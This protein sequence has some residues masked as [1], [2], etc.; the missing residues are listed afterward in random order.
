MIRLL[1]IYLVLAAGLSAAGAW[2][3]LMVPDG[4]FGWG[5]H[6]ACLRFSWILG[7]IVSANI[8]V[9]VEYRLIPERLRVVRQRLGAHLGRDFEHQIKGFE[10]FIFACG[11]GHLLRPIVLFVPSLLPVLVA[12]DW[13]TL[14]ASRSARLTVEG[15]IQ[16]IEALNDERAEAKAEALRLRGD[17]ARLTASIDGKVHQAFD[18]VAS[19]EALRTALEAMMQTS[20][21]PVVLYDLDHLTLIIASNGFWRLMGRVPQRGIDLLSIIHPDEHE[22][23]REACRERPL[24]GINPPAYHTRHLHADGSTVWLT[25]WA[26]YVPEKGEA[27]LAWFRVRRKEEH[28]DG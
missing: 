15:T 5:A 12:A 17:V 27:P 11:A 7:P 2:R 24:S 18:L 9:A 28:T 4:I 6:A 22:A 26:G 14:A 16:R 23:A 19:N 25:F 3:W 10:R 1:A 8:G 13:W 20:E 21:E